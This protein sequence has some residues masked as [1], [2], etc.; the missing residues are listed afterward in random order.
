M[1]G[2]MRIRPSKKLVGD[3]PESAQ[4]GTGFESRRLVIFDKTSQLRFLIDTGSDVSIIPATR[5]D[6]AGG[7]VPF[8]LHAA[9]G[10]KIRK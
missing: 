8:S 5:Q 10:T 4:V 6:R 2:T 7:T 3:P 1:Q 9:N